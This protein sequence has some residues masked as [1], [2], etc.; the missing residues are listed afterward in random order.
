MNLAEQMKEKSL[1]YHAEGGKSEVDGSLLKF[2]EWRA[3][4]GDRK[5][6]YLGDSWKN[7][8][9]TKSKL[10]SYGFKVNVSWLSYLLCFP[11]P[12]Y[13]IRW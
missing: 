10:E 7:V 9:K 13:I 2:I 4:A 5:Y 1:A 11:H 3:E 6:I 12:E 8:K